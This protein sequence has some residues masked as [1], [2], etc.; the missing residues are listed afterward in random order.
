MH[1]RAPSSELPSTDPPT[2]PP[3]ETPQIGDPA[4]HAP[5]RAKDAV[6]EQAEHGGVGQGWLCAWYL[7]WH[8]RGRRSVPMGHVSADRAVP[9]PG[10]QAPSSRTL[11]QA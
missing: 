4:P 3:A 7:Q 5:G 11:P 1:A 2:A 9:A 10:H 8:P 6:N